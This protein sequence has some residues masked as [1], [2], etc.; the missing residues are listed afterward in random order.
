MI[1]L[2][3]VQ[4]VLFVVGILYCCSPYHLCPCCSGAEAARI[5][6]EEKEEQEEQEDALENY[7]RE[8]E[9]EEQ[10]RKK[11]HVRVHTNER[12]FACNYCDYA[13]AQKSNLKR[14]IKSQHGAASGNKK[15]TISSASDSSPSSSE[16]SSEEE[17]EEE[18]EQPMQTKPK[19]QTHRLLSMFG[20]TTVSMQVSS[21]TSVHAT[22]NSTAMEYSGCVWYVKS[23]SNI[24][25]LPVLNID[26]LHYVYLNKKKQ[27]IKY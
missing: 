21:N 6:Q 22:P 14:H 16:A 15:S 9:Q 7:R 1:V 26:D 10:K 27:T 17:E 25:Q 5:A 4:V 24:Y 23:V 8:Q 19:K 3:F 2:I 12:P 20:G 13:A 11:A 18:D